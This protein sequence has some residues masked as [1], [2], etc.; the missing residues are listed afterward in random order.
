MTVTLFRENRLD[1]AEFHSP[2]QLATDFIAALRGEKFPGYEPSGSCRVDD[3][4]IWWLADAKGMNST[5]DRS[6]WPA[7]I[8]ALG[9]LMDS[10]DSARRTILDSLPRPAF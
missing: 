1:Q 9:A 3:Q 6:D 2:E 4:F 7:L 8:D 5:W 10:D